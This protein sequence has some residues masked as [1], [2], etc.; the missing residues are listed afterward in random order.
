MA[1]LRSTL[2][3]RTAV[4]SR[5]SG[6]KRWG[7]KPLDPVAGATRGRIRQAKQQQG[8][9]VLTL[10]QAQEY[11]GISHNGLLALSRRGVIH[12]NQ[13]TDF[14]PWRIAR[15]EL[16]SDEVQ[17]LVR[18]LKATG[19]L[20]K[21]GSPESQPGLFDAS[22]GVTSKVGREHHDLRRYDPRGTTAE[23]AEAEPGPI[24]GAGRG[25]REAG[26]GAPAAAPEHAL[27]GACMY[28]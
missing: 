20:P 9:D 2:R 1:S 3:S 11:L 5:F 8:K 4:C 17:E 7:G 18:V 10:S 13:V 15:Q 27:A 6:G 19:R 23:G 16:D 12:S 14:A 24:P 22:N 28:A 21:G 26:D 25:P